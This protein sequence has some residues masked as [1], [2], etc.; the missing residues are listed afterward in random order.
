MAAAS[1]TCPPLRRTSGR[2]PCPL[3]PAFRTSAS[4]VAAALLANGLAK[5]TNLG[6]EDGPQPVGQVVNEVDCRTMNYQW[7]PAMEW[8][9]GDGGFSSGT[10]AAD[11]HECSSRC[12]MTAGC[13][14]WSHAPSGECTLSDGNARPRYVEGVIA[15][16]ATRDCQCPARA[17]P[18]NRFPGATAELTQAAW[19]PGHGQPLGLECWPKQPQSCDKVEVLQDTQS[20]WPGLCMDLHHVALQSVE[21]CEANC[22][23]NVLCAVWQEV[24]RVGAPAGGGCWQ[25]VG[26]RCFSRDN[27]DD[28]LPLAA[29]RLQHGQIS[30]LADTSGYQVMNLFCPF[31]ADYFSDTDTAVEECRRQCYSDI[32]CTHWQYI[33]ST[34][35]WRESPR[36]SPVVDYPLIFGQNARRNHGL[37]IIAGEYIQHYCGRPRAILVTTQPPAPVARQNFAGDNEPSYDPRTLLIGLGVLLCCIISTILGALLCANNGQPKSARNLGLEEDDLSIASARSWDFTPRSRSRSLVK[38][39]LVSSLEEAIDRRL[40]DRWAPPM[41]SMASSFG[42]PTIAYSAVPMSEGQMLQQSIISHGNS[43]SL[44]SVASQP[45]TATTR[46]FGFVGD[47]RPF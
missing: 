22:R 8:H 9:A 32:L 43:L 13:W 26:T 23:R 20:G 12:M 46:G 35:C 27:A 33:E 36:V 10:H 28:V 7:N 4:A 34:G 47:D 18:P 44:A 41:L 15:G 42:P 16:P 11:P 6:P 1:S 29:Q 2:V 39:A 30:L 45:A 38:P 31:G 5:A 37:N 21:T 19:G 3:G 40:V 14:R 24:P 17:P 25:G